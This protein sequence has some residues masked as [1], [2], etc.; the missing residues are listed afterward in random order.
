[1]SNIYSVILAGGSGSRLWP[2]SRDMHPKQLLKLSEDY[3]LFQSTFLRL[4]N[5]VNDKNIITIT[6]IKHESIVKQQL[7][8]IKTKFCR[9]S[10][11]KVITEPISKNTA[12]AIALSVKYIMEKIAV[13]ETDPVILVAPS[14]QLIL[15]EKCFS[16]A[17]EE[18]QKLASAGYIVTFG[19]EPQKID[20]GLG[21]IKTKKDKKIAEF[22]DAAQKVAEFIEKP[23]HENAVKFVKSKKYLWNSGIFMFKASIFMAELKKHCPE[24]HKIINN[25]ELTDTAPSVPYQIFDKM[26][27]ISIDYALMEK[28]KKLAAVPMDCNWADLGSWE[29]IYEISEKDKNGNYI[30][31]NVID[32]ESKNS[33][34][35]STSKLVTTIGLENTIVVETEDAL[36][37]CNKDNAQDVKKIYNKLKSNN[38]AAHLVHKTM[39]RPWGY[40]TV[41]QEGEGFL[42][43]CIVVNAGAKLSVQL[44][45]HRSEHWV[46]LEGKAK[47]L[48]GEEFIELIPGESVDLAVE[49]IHSLQNPYNEPLKILEVQRGSILDENDIERLEDIYGRA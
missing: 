20:I 40:Y 12:P 29:T 38:D 2:L 39:Y 15:N 37:V 18:G 26:P 14:D 13:S 17:L 46:V 23:E 30:S 32:F 19:V 1:M 11:Y 16:D 48:K 44:H 35:Y 41:L 33:M 49:E 27:D 21:Y 10:D 42:T 8:E 6:N 28:S 4:I 36:L 9:K 31:G 5:D 7:D 22:S 43:K 45:H 24:I 25:I 34:I 47:V 3:T